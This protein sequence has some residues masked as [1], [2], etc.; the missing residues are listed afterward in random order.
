KVWRPAAVGAMCVALAAM[1]WRDVRRNLDWKDNVSLAIQ[2]A[3]DNLSSSKACAWAGM[4]LVTQTSE[5]Q[6]N[7]LGEELL[8]RAIDLYPS[9]GM[10]YWELA[11]Y[12]GRQHRFADSVIYLSKA[13]M[14][15]AGL[16]ETRVALAS[17]AD[18]L[19]TV[20]A[21]KFMPALE[22]NLKQ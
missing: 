7:A 18:D 4:V 11:K 2:T 12:L 3:S 1:G 13:A 8:R 16:Q 15:R 20:P 21:E 17:A 14:Y 9:F 6:F 5:P 10:S 22:E 19:K